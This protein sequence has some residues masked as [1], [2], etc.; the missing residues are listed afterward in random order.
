[1]K[2][3]KLSLFVFL[4]CILFASL[5]FS[6]TEP[7]SFKL[8]D[9]DFSKAVLPLSF[10]KGLPT[11][12][13]KIQAKPFRLIL[14]TGADFA[15][16]CLRPHV[17]EK[18]AVNY[19]DSGDIT[20]D[21][22]GRSYRN[23]H[24]VIPELHLGELKFTDFTAGEE[25]RDF[26]PADGII[27][28]RFLKNFYVLFDYQKSRAV[29]Y[30]KGE[31]P[32]ELKLNKW[33]RIPF[34]HNNIGIIINV[35][36]DAFDR[37]LKFCLDSGSGSSGKKKSGLLRTINPEGL[38]Q[39]KGGLVTYDHV[40]IA[41]IELGRVDFLIAD[42]KEPPVDG[43]FGDYFFSRFKTLIDFDRDVLFVKE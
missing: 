1:M 36:I 5:C 7:K 31:Y 3:F 30:P 17:L 8:V 35:K 27:G 14:D 23:R 26:V 21:I 16:I 29:L 40:S 11:V 34:E 33:R 41:G 18:I 15:T 4:V 39:E 42:F 37:E 12:E 20:L 10:V 13:V 22:H 38:S 9:E 32:S 6:E 2:C 28:N 43:F 24:F 25:L 19:L